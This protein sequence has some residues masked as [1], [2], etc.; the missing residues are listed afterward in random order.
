MITA[1]NLY[2]SRI[3]AY[4]MPDAVLSFTNINTF[5]LQ[6]ISKVGTVITAL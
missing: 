4:Y 5:N 1:E 2:L 3:C 6:N